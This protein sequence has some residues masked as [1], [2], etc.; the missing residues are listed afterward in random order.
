M[1]GKS[2]HSLMYIIG[3]AAMVIVSL[4]V[5]KRLGLKIWNS[6]LFT[7]VAFLSDGLG[8]FL[9]GKV[10]TAVVASLGGDGVSNYAIYGAVFLTPVLVMLSARVINQ[11]WR[12]ILDMVAL[13]EMFARAFGKTGCIFFGCCWG[14]EC[15]YGMYNY[16][17]QKNMFPSPIFEAATM[18]II[19]FVGFMIL[20]KSKSYTPGCLYPI[21]SLLYAG[22]RFFWEFTRY[23][24]SEAEKHLIMGMSLWQVCSIITVALSVLWLVGIKQDWLGKAKAYVEVKQAEKAEAER[25]A[26]A[27]KRRNKKKRKS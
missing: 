4:C 15:D 8:A 12:Q 27:E 14:F 3:T 16:L 6:L 18:L 23:Y 9:M 11:P 19:I 2:L 7:V 20:Y 17:Q 21:M 25:K 10:Y 5:R 26:R 24:T 22:T 1:I 13:G